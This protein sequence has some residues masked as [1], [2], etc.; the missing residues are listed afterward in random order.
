VS[1]HPFSRPPLVR[2][3][4]PPFDACTDCCR[5]EAEHQAAADQRVTY[6]RD[7][8]R[9]WDGGQWADTGALT[10]KVAFR[11]ADAIRQLLALIDEGEADGAQLA[12][13]RAIIA[14]FDWEQDDRQYALE[15]IKQ[16]VTGGG[17]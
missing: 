10:A 2:P 4:L 15:K 14:A 12:E 17:R 1:G 8:L 5:P 6:A 16:I 7:A 13:V 9:Y 3:D 11:L